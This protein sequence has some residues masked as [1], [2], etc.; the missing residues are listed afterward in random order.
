M[1]EIETIKST[2]DLTRIVSA[3]SKGHRFLFRGQNVYLPPLPRIG[4]IAKERKLSSDDVIKI[5]QQMLER[6]RHESVPFLQGIQPQT[7]FDWLSI[8]QHHGLPTRLLDWTASALA[9]LCFAV[10]DDPP[11][12]VKEGVIWVL[13]VHPD[14]EKKPSPDESLF[15]LRRTYIFQPFHID[16]RIAAQAGWFSIHRYSDER[17]KFFSL[18]RIKVFKPKLKA[19]PVSK[20]RFAQLRDELRLLGITQATLFPDL[21]GLCAEIE[22]ENLRSFRPIPTI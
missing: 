5:E 15:D 13:E 7:D 2:V 19:Y 14:D 11:E 16:R 18:D 4:R 6:F 21:S 17:G 8:A 3:L 1:A 22:A 12:D 9:A 20:D 10:A